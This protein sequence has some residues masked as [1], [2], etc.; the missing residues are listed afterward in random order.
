MVSA[1]V[2]W[3]L[4]VLLSSLDTHTPDVGEVVGQVD[5]QRSAEELDLFVGRH[6]AVDAGT[7]P[8]DPTC[9]RLAAAQS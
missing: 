3:V 1:V 2:P 8:V 9:A 5:R 4:Y 6:V 7:K